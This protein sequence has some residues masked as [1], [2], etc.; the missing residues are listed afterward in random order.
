[1]SQ[2]KRDADEHEQKL[3]TIRTLVK[4]VVLVDHFPDASIPEL[5]E[6]AKFALA[7]L[8]QEHEDMVELQRKIEKDD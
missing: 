2:V 6:K 8:D 5:Y 1:M 3:E 7:M 4:M